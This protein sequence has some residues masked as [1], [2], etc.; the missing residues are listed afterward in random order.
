MFS[1]AVAVVAA[2]AVEAVRAR[3][4]EVERYVVVVVV[5]VVMWGLVVVV[6]TLLDVHC[7]LLGLT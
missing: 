5:V 6:V 3:C 1:V 2:A 7:P 4:F